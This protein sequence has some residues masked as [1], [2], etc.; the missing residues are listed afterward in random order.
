MLFLGII[1]WKGVSCFNGGGWG[2]GLLSRWGVPHGGRGSIGFGG[3][4]GVEKHR[5][6]GGVPSEKHR[7][8]KCIW[9]LLLQDF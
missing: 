2:G 8:L 9:P 5:K 7:F 3:G 6:M 4:G 1:S